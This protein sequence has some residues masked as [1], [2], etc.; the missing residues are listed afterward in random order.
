[1][2]I[3]D[4][5]AIGLGP[6]NLSL[7]ALTQPLDQADALFLEQRSDFNWHPG[8]ML[9]GTHLQ[10]PFMSDLVTLADPTSPYSFL[11]YLKQHQKLYRFYIRENFFILRHEYNLYCQWVCRQLTNLRFNTRV[12][13]IS[14]DAEHHCYRLET[15]RPDGQDNGLY[16]ARKLVIGTGPVP[17]R[18]DG[19]DTLGEHAIHSSE[20]LQQ[21]PTL[22]EQPRIS[23]IG[24][25][26]SAAEIVYDL[27][28]E[29]RQRSFH[30]DWITRSPRYFPLE[31]S[32]LTLEMTSPE[33]VDYFH[34]LPMAT[35]D[36]LLSQ[37]QNLYKGINS[38]LI[39]AIF[40]RLYEMDLHHAPRVRLLTNTAVS[41][42][43]ASGA[44]F[45][46]SLDHQ[47]Q[48]RHATLTTN[49]LIFATGYRAAL[50]EFLGGIANEI[51]WDSKERLAVSRHYAIDKQQ[52]LFVQN[53]ELHSHGF[54]TPDLGMA[55][56]RNSVLLHKL[57]GWQPYAVEKKIAFQQFGFDEAGA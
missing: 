36:T 22:L 34:S 1:M 55:C 20:Y 6:F 57:L 21:K 35:R 27:L 49:A 16:Y 12:T 10:T 24:G 19:C 50:P 41:R 7:A 5:I 25:G 53:A 13:A 38:D 30:L 17:H 18:P 23:V 51:C 47:E 32:K 31:Y 9:E 44:E 8:M 28:D 43:E 56:Y 29:Q 15:R 52:R 40:D 48:Q 4:F 45:H 26:Q 33:Y 3:Y 54:V 11:N 14:F 46:L 42:V 2:K 39:N 37:Q